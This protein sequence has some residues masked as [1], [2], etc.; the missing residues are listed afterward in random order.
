M[1]TSLDTL[2]SESS[3][4]APEIPPVNEFER[5]I[6]LL[7]RAENRD[8]FRLLGPHISD[9][10]EEK[11]LVVRGFFPEPAKPLSC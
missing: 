8:V 4:L 7:L 2:R 10:G 6:T 1:E 9:E 11:R 3:E 5:D